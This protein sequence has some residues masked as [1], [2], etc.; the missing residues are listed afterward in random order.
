MAAPAWAGASPGTEGIFWIGA[1]GEDPTD[2]IGALGEE[3]VSS[4][5]FAFDVDVVE[6]RGGRLDFV[7]ALDLVRAFYGQG[8]DFF[9]VYGILVL[10]PTTLMMWV[11]RPSSSMAL[12]MVLPSMARVLS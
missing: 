8:A 9:W 12:H 4:D 1:P 6:K 3:G 2:W 7:C 5:G 11:C 10:W